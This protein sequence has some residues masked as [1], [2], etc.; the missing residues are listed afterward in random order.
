MKVHLT[1]VVQNRKWTRLMLACAAGLG[2]W[3]CEGQRGEPVSVVVTPSRYEFDIPKGWVKSGGPGGNVIC[4]VPLPQCQAGTGGVP[5]Y[6]AA[7]IIFSEFKGN[8]DAANREASRLVSTQRQE[9]DDQ[10]SWVATS[11][12]DRVLLRTIRWDYQSEALDPIPRLR[13]KVHYL[14]LDHAIV[15]AFL[16]YWL[17]DPRGHQYEKDC[18]Q[19]LKSVKR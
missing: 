10:V 18:E 12:F 6:N 16:M 15:K 19:M 1:R 11:E 14:F 3:K 8:R 4:S 17:D 13:T 7:Q 9:R 2:L 5:N